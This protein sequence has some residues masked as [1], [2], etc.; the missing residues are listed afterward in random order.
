MRPAFVPL[1]MTDGCYEQQPIAQH[2]R[3]IHRCWFNVGQR[4]C[5][6]ANSEPTRVQCPVFPGKEPRTHIH[7][8]LGY[9]RGL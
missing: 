5:R 6:W 2:T 4:R 8:V 9:Y 7:I 1:S 3:D